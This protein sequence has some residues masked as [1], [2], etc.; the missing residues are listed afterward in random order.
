[1]RKGEKSQVN[2]HL[3]RKEGK[4]KGVGDANLIIKTQALS[5]MASTQQKPSHPTSP[6]PHCVL[7]P[8]HQRG[9][10]PPKK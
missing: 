7:S 4:R 1:M 10:W 8:G 3:E 5:L 2:R 6:W 9:S